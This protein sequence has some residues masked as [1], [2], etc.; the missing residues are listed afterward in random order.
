MNRKKYSF[1]KAICTASLG[2]STHSGKC[3]G[4]ECDNN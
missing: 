3:V 1:Y 2:V 4:S